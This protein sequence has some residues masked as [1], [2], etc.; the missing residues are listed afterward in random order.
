[1]NVQMNEFPEGHV[2][3]PS[4]EL[5]ILHIIKVPGLPEVA[6]AENYRKINIR[7]QDAVSLQNNLLTR[8]VSCSVCAVYDPPFAG[9]RSFAAQTPLGD[10]N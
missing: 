7:K 3:V 2:K 5:F 8:F 10:G 6:E 1:M 9:T 4:L